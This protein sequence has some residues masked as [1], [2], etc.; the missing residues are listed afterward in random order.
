MIKVSVHQCLLVLALACV[1]D[2]LPADQNDERL[3]ALFQ[4]LQSTPAG[5]TSNSIEE[6]IWAIWYNSGDENIDRLMSL[7]AN[8]ADI[9]RLDAAEHLYNQVIEK[10]PNFSE[11]WNRRATIRYYKNDYK[12]SLDDI[13]QTLRLEP[14]HFGSVWGLGMILS[15]QKNYPE[16]IA[17][18][19][20]LLKIKP[21]AQNAHEQIEW[22]KD[23]LA[24]R[25]I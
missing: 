23:Q 5:Q 19:E 20:Y 9:G 14:R 4:Q 13:Q 24:K 18:F 3:D 17:A 10:A 7:A 1:H 11:G 8:A 2:T 25:T 21:N 15:A 22:L 12:G 16:A 6:K